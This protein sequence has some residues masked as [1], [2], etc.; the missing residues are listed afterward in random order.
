MDEELNAEPGS[1]AVAGAAIETEAPLTVGIFNNFILNLADGTHDLNANTIKWYIADAVPSPEDDT[2][3]AHLKEIVDS[4]YAGPYDLNNSGSET[5][6]VY[7]VVGDAS[8]FVAG[9][10]WSTDIR[11]IALFDEDVFGDPLIIFYDL[12]VTL[13]IAE[14]DTFKLSFSG[15][16]VGGDVLTIT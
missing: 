2:L 7:T 12:G 1:Y 16:D 9:V 8:S 11:Y 13:Q 5:G 4:G 3:K 6:G 15:V 10:G 14:G